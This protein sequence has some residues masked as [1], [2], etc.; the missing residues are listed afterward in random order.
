MAFVTGG[1]SLVGGVLGAAGA[2]YR[3]KS[4]Y[5]PGCFSDQLVSPILELPGV[6]EWFAFFSHQ[7]GIASFQIDHRVEQGLPEG[8][9]VRVCQDECLRQF[10]QRSMTGLALDILDL[11]FIAVQIPI[12]HRFDPGMAVNAIE[13]VL[14]FREL[15]DG[16]VVVMQTVCGG[17]L[18][19]QE[20]NRMQIVIAAIVAGIALGVGDGCRE[21]VDIFCSFRIHTA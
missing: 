6:P 13:C 11:L 19:R 16:L 4:E 8:D 21:G 15:S 9:V 18:A 2:L 5:L 1:R 3:F 10:C 14:A 7:D 12:P 17:I 20:C